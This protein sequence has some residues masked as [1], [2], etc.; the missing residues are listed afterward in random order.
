[1]HKPQF[2]YAW[3]FY[4]IMT[5][6]WMTAKDWMALARYRKKGL[7]KSSGF[8]ESQLVRKMLMSK[9][10]YF[11]YIIGLPAHLQRYIVLDD[12]RRM[13]GD[14]RRHRHDVGMHFPARTRP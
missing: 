14:A 12:S 4:G 13:D 7:I 9:A 1:M 11:G 10:L 2:I 5:I 8:S 3:F 6:F